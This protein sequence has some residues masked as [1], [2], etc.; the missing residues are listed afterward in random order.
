M[1]N[2]LEHLITKPAAEIRHALRVARL[3]E[4][5]TGFSMYFYTI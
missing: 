3:A 1:D 5:E 4:V 2:R